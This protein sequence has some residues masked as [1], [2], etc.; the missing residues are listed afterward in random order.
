MRYRKGLCKSIGMV[1]GGTGIT[2]LFQ[3]IR[4]ICEDPTDITTVSVVYG[5]RTES[6]IMLKEKMD[7]FA[8]QCPEK[9]KIWYTLDQPGP[10]W[11]GGKGYVSKELLGERMP[12]PEEGVKIL[13]CGPPGMVNATKKNLVEL[14]FE[15]PGAVSK[16]SDQVFCF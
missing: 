7:A 4:A 10:G 15:S 16:M 14:G 3:L 2:P 12:K 11:Q 8:K 6:D 5:N 1:G 9:F 13:L